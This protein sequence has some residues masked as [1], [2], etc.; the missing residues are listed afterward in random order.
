MEEGSSSPESGIDGQKK[1]KRS[2]Y[3]SDSE[4]Q[5]MHGDSTSETNNGLF[6]GQT[7]PTM[8]HVPR[9]AGP[10][11]RFK[12][13]GTASIAELTHDQPA[14]L[15]KVQSSMPNL[16]PEIWQHVFTF[17]PPTFLGRLFRVN[18][19][20]KGLLSPGMTFPQIQTH[21]QTIVSLQSQDHI[22][23]VSRRTFFPGMPRPMFSMSEMDMWKLLQSRSC[24]F[25][26]KKAIKDLSSSSSSPWSSGPGP[27]NVRVIWPFA[28]RSC[29][30]CLSTR[31]V[32]ASYVPALLKA[33]C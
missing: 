5:T 17:V 6:S 27:D 10:S 22:W 21:D 2:P 3:F 7:S 15:S 24:Q 8:Q 30:P 20:F 25:C 9:L 13:E 11:K 12:L 28:V 26:G 32:K 29:G 19:T 18:S 33:Y 16:P 31:L 4:S 1:R 23:S 14:D